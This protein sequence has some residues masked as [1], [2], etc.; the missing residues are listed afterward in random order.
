[1][2]KLL[3]SALFALLILV[4]C[5]AYRTPDGGIAFDIQIRIQPPDAIP[6]L[7][8]TP[9]R[10]LTPTVVATIVPTV[11]PSLTV[12][13][14]IT[15]EDPPPTRESSA[16]FIA[17]T[18]LPPQQGWVTASTLNVRRCPVDCEVA[19]KIFFSQLVHIVGRTEDGTWLQIEVPGTLIMGWVASRFIRQDHQ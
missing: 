15:P 11:Q 3:A 14:T 9:T 6:T 5:D 13:P 8:P 7:Q 12:A 18:P 17:D 4:G 19:Y 1:M 2:R 16:T 10:T